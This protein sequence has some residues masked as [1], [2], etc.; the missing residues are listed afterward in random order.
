M[1]G[2]QAI[3]RVRDFLDTHPGAAPYQVGLFLDSLETG[4]E[5]VLPP[6]DLP[7]A[8]EPEEKPGL[9]MRAVKD[10]G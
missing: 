4:P 7:L 2:K 9:S 1:T 8:P 3:A 5:E 10:P 6:V